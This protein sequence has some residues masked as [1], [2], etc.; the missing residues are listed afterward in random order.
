MTREEKLKSI[1]WNDKKVK[2]WKALREMTR[3]E[4]LKSFKRNDKRGKTE[5]H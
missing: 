5:K 2:N 1:K 3:E 4:K